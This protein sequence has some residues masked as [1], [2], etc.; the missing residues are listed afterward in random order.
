MNFKIKNC[1]DCQI[2]KGRGGLLCPAPTFGSLPEDWW[3][4]ALGVVAVVFLGTVEDFGRAYPV[5]P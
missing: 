1:F 2:R 3:L 5:Q 4:G